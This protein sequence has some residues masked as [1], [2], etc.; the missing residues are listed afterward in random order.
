MRTR[1]GSYG[2]TQ[3]DGTLEGEQYMACLQGRT[4][5]HPDGKSGIV[6]NQNDLVA[7]A[8]NG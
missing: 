2:L 6:Y 1:D 7:V 8:T 4:C 3:G 5:P